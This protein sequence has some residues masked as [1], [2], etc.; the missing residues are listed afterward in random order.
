MCMNIEHPVLLDSVSFL[1]C[2]LRTLPDVYGLT[3]SKSWYHHYFNS[4]GNL[5]YVG[6]IPDI[7]NY[8]VNVKCEEEWSEFLAWYES[9]KS[10]VFDKRSMLEK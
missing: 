10:E 9:H 3:A 1:P 4:D 2:A 5:D 7:K 6:T 8:C